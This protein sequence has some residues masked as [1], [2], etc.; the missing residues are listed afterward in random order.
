MSFVSLFTGAASFTVFFGIAEEAGFLA[1]HGQDS[2]DVHG[3]FDAFLLDLAAQF[4]RRL[5]IATVLDIVGMAA[6]AAEELGP[7]VA[8]DGLVED[9]H[10]AEERRQFRI[11]HAVIDIADDVVVLADEL[12]AR[13]DIAVGDDTHVFMTGTA[14]AQALG[15]TGTAVEIHDEM[16]V[17]EGTAFI[18]T[19]QVEISQ[20]V[21]F[22][23]NAGQIVVR[24]GIGQIV[25]DD[26]FH[27]QAFKA[28]VGHVFYV[29]GKIEVVF[30]IRPADVIFFTIAM[31]G[32]IDLI[33]RTG[34]IGAVATGV[35]AHAVV[36]FRTAVEAEDEADVVIRQILDFRRVEKH[37]VRRQGQFE[38]FIVDLFLFPDVFDG[39]L[40]DAEVHQRFAAEEVDFAVLAFA[41][42]TF[43]K[44][45]DSPFGYVEAHE[46]P[47]VRII[48]ALRGKAVLTAQVAVVRDVQA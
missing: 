34:L 47:L 2:L 14:A 32:S 5:D 11:G 31:L 30:C 40:D 18:H 35:G 7:A 22:F 10:V 21:I 3:T 24:N 45:V 28:E 33:V 17:N 38:D 20:A 26:R 42:C 25:T 6:A 39:L 9:V 19:L 16:I 15:D 29:F 41:F 1:A 23:V 44:Q 48:I 46:F 4:I 37:A 43:D 36:D 8:A 27:G 12:M 13:I